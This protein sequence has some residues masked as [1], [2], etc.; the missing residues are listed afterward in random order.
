MHTYFCAHMYV[1]VNNYAIVNPGTAIIDPVSPA[2]EETGHKE[3]LFLPKLQLLRCSFTF[4]LP[5]PV[6]SFPQ[7]LS[8][9]HN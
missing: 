2:G 1:S 9:F 7:P 6:P 8:K 5:H 3:E 4:T